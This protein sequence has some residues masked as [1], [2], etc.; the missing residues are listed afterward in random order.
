[1]SLTDEGPDGDLAD[2]LARG[3]SMK[4]DTAEN[5]E[6]WAPPHIDSVG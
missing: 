1:M 5:W 3:D 4:E 6:S 2:E